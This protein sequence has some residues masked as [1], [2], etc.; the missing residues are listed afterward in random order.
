MKGDNEYLI[1]LHISKTYRHKEG[2]SMH[3]T[4]KRAIM[5]RLDG[6]LEAYLGDKLLENRKCS[7]EFYKGNRQRAAAFLKQ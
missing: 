4:L 5:M 1:H 2:K 6:R 3:A 7:L